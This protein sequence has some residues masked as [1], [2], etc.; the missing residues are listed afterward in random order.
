MTLLP[1][2]LFATLSLVSAAPAPSYPSQITPDLDFSTAYLQFFR[3]KQL[4]DQ[5]NIRRFEEFGLTP[6]PDAEAKSLDN[7][8]IPAA[9]VIAETS[10]PADKPAENDDIPE[11]DLTDEAIMSD[12]VGI[13]AVPEPPALTEVTTAQPAPVDT[14]SVTVRPREAV[15]DSEESIK[16]PCLNNFC[17]SVSDEEVSTST[18]ATDVD[19]TTV[20]APEVTTV[21]SSEK[22]DVEVDPKL[23]NSEVPVNP[24]PVVEDEDESLNEI[25]TG[26]DK[27]FVSKDT[28]SAARK[29]GYKILFKKIGG[30]EVP[31]GKI[32]FSLPTIVEITPEDDKVVV[33]A[34]EDISP[35]M[36][37]IEEVIET[38]VAPTVIE[39]TTDAV[40]IDMRKESED[41]IDDDEVTTV[42]VDN[43][44]SLDVTTAAPAEE[45]V[46]TLLSISDLLP[47]PIT[48]VI[49]SVDIG[50]A[51][52]SDSVIKISEETE[53]ALE[54]IKNKTS[55]RNTILD[56]EVVKLISE[57]CDCVL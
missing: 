11:I 46:T 29:Y 33:E 27:F 26:S 53:T 6:V 5:I 21:A 48:A 44:A 3:V 16:M 40:E 45:E 14:D 56:D 1:L 36:E 57:R 39:K 19:V 31:V 38:T 15:I 41:E 7:I 43:N 52:I 35:K 22:E 51:S 37:I 32:K 54:E 34:L 23:V 55:V 4:I 12:T 2:T 50:D 24:G 30:K 42:T 17:I 28:I 8:I 49:P 25:D 18:S 9:E 10:V 13:V 47:E 20:T